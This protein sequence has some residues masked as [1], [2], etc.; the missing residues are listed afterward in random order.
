MNNTDVSLI[1]GFKIILQEGS[2]PEKLWNKN[3]CNFYNKTFLL[4]FIEHKIDL[5]SK[6]SDQNTLFIVTLNRSLL[7]LINKPMFTNSDCNWVIITNDA[8]TKTFILFKK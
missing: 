1:N 7:H 8:I 3:G 6:Y 4:L 5:Y 2:T